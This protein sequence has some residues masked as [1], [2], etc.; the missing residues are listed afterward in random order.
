[1]GS[2]NWTPE[3]V[4]VLK[5]AVDANPTD[6]HSE[7]GSVA[8][9]VKKSKSAVRS[10]YA[11]EYGK[12]RVYKRRGRKPKQENIPVEPVVEIKK[13]APCKKKYN[14]LQRAAKKVFKI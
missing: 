12:D 11:R 14:W 13:T 3:E 2:K 7:F 1:M 5:S 6:P 4:Q 9:I 8:A 10:K